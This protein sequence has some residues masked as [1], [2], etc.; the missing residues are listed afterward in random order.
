MTTSEVTA[1]SCKLSW[2]PPSD[3]GGAEVTD[4]IIEKQEE[5]SQFWERVIG[6]VQKESITAKGLK[7][8]RGCG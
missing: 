7:V 8:Q 5:V 2:K 4:Y 1:E 3:N 6:N